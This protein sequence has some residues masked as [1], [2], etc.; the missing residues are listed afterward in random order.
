MEKVSVFIAPVLYALEQARE[1][2]PRFM[3]GLS[4]AQI[5]AQPFGLAPVGFQL[6]HIARSIDRLMTYLSG[7]QLD[8][9]QMEALRTEM[10]PGESRE[11]LLR[12][13][14][15]ALAQAAAKIRAIDPDRLA[16]PRVVGRKRLPTTV[17]GLAVHIAEHT[18]RHV[19]Q[20]IS[21]AKL[22]RAAEKI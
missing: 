21:A 19:G 22:A 8:T 6:R 18:Q 13:V 10:E 2:L 16:E 11:K 17:I 5:W 20:A 12:E 14:D 3:K 7:G 4:D 9:A 1:D 15:L